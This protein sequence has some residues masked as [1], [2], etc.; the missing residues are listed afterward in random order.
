MFI[1]EVSLEA[2][3]VMDDDGVD[4]MEFSEAFKIGYLKGF[5]CGLGVA[6]GELSDFDMF[7]DNII[8]KRDFKKKWGKISLNNIT[9]GQIADGISA[10]YE[11]F[12]NRRTKLIDAIYVVKI[13]IEGK[14]SELINAQIRYLKMQPISWETYMKYHK[15][16]RAFFVKNGRYPTYKEIKNSDYSFEEVLK[17]GYFID[18]NN[19]VHA[20][21]CYGDYK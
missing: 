12:S 10:F 3:D 13:Q 5:L 2:N 8:S 20:L 1:S 18:T 4:W 17:A 14:N 19:D 15:K 7:I 9:I 21:F 11:D 6:E 16:F